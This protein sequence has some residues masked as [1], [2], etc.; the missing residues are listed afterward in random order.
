[1]TRAHIQAVE[2]MV[3]A[4][5]ATYALSFRGFL[6]QLVTIFVN[7]VVRSHSSSGTPHHPPQ[8]EGPDCEAVLLSLSP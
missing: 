7:D 1:M 8:F 2:H 5:G 3:N 4:K 6:R